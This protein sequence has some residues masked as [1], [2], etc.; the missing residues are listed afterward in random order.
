MSAKAVMCV[1][2]LLVAFAAGLVGPLLGVH[3]AVAGVDHHMVLWHTC[4][5][6]Q[7]LQKAVQIQDVDLEVPGVRS[8]NQWSGVWQI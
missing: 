2:I 8:S 6:A 3:N 5:V 1:H 7:R 4:S